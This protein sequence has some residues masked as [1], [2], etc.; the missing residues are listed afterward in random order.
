L[1]GASRRPDWPSLLAAYVERFRDERFA[2][3]WNDCL[4]FVLRWERIATERSRF[5]D[6]HF[7]YSTEQ[8]ANTLMAMHQVYDVAE[9]CD[10]RLDRVS[11][12]KAQR[13]DI[14]GQNLRG[15]IGLAICLGNHFAYPSGQRL[16]FKPMQKAVCAWRV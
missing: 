12:K 5:L 14:I 8:E 15:Q 10:L 11:P 9:V 2:W 4:T 7:I 6:A 16:R 13:G 3:G 1:S